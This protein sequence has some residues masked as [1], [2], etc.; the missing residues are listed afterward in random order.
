MVYGIIYHKCIV[1]RCIWM[2]IILVFIALLLVPDMNPFLVYI[3]LFLHDMWVYGIHRLFHCLPNHPLNL[4][5]WLHHNHG[6]KLSKGVNLFF[7]FLVDLFYFGLVGIIQLLCGVYVFNM[8]LIAYA[9]IIYS[10]VHIFIMHNTD[11]VYHELHHEYEQYNFTP[12]GMDILFSS[13]YE[14]TNTSLWNDVLDVLFGTQNGRIDNV[15]NFTIMG[16]SSL[17]AVSLLSSYH[18]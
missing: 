18:F 6:L 3:Q 7:E 12:K 8:Y 14:R 4:H 1:G 13:N 2:H 10:S 16:F 9:A 5:V 15:G 11:V 17:L